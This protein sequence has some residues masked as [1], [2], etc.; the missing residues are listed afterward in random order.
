VEK[1]QNIVDV[2]HLGH[3]TTSQML[4]FKRTDRLLPLI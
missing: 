2:D 1:F 4:W 3:L